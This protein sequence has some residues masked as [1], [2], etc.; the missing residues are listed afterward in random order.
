MGDVLAGCGCSVVAARAVASDA[1]MI[2][3][4]WSPSH[5]GM[6]VLTI[7]ATRNMRRMFSCR[8]NA[9]VA[10]VT[11]TNHLGVIDRK[12]RREHVGA[13]AILANVTGIDVRW[14]LADCF[15]AIVAV[16][17]SAGNVSVIKVCR[18]PARAR[19]AVIARVTASDVSL[20]LTGSQYAVV[21]GATRT[22]DLGMVDY[23][24]GCE[25]TGAVA[26][27]ADV[28]RLNVTHRLAG[29]GDAIVTAAAVVDDIGVIEIG[30]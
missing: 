24:D 28:C 17:A 15:D 18:N 27:L 25:N 26:V 9:I 29:R 30:W 3:G 14:R 13:M 12:H 6:A 4:R 16:K 11:C 5:S 21:T 1:D 19:V 20:I 10:R 22:N 7:V 8:C 23:S 2:K